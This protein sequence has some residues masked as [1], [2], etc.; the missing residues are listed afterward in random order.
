[1]E[2]FWKKFKSILKKEKVFVVS[3]IF[4]VITSV[5]S[6]PKL[7]YIN[8]EVVI[9]MFNL[10]IVIKAFENLRL[11]DKIAVGILVKQKNI[12]MVSLMLTFLCFFSSMIITNDVA[13]ITFVP[14]TMIVAKKAEINPL[15]IIIMETLAVNI[16]SSFTPIGNPQNL[17]LFSFF[18]IRVLDFFKI[19]I[20]LT[21]IG[22]LW[23][24]ILN[25]RIL[26]KNFNSD[27]NKVEIKNKGELAIFFGLFIVILLSVFNVVDYRFTFVITL[28][29]TF[30][31][32]KKLFKEVDYFL[33]ITFICFFIAIGNISNIAIIDEF[34]RKFLTNISNVYFSSIF[35]S[36]IISNLP[37]AILLSKF[38]SSWKEILIGV[39]IGGMGTMIAS[40]ASLISYKFY[41]KEYDGKQYFFKFTIYNFVSLTVFTL[42]CYE[43]LMI[44]K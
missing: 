35:L 12:R 16:G 10:M 29:I 26:N 14:L 11:L 39:N 40:L 7:N 18:N 20:F 9:L 13:L 17:Y 36:Q 44:Y 24:F 41:S 43:F 25:Y 21:V 31:V 30:I 42:I 1:M 34:M 5:M 37:C 4:A 33:L 15:K 27:L 23:L 3:L 2:Q 6:L 19:T 32:E 8:F 22:L 28:I 38:T